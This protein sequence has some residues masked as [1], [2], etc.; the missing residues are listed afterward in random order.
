MLYLLRYFMLNNLFYYFVGV[1]SIANGT[2]RVITTPALSNIQKNKVNNKK[3]YLY[4]MYLSKEIIILFVLFQHPAP[5][6]DTPIYGITPGWKL[7]PPAP[8]LRITKCPNGK[9][10]KESFSF[11]LMIHEK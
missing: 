6:P 2:V 5:L 1:S 7:P 4:D 8:S 3:F 9:D 11:K 10:G